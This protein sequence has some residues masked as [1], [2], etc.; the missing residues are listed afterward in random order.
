MQ[1]IPTA[2]YLRRVRKLLTESERIRAEA[3]IA[4]DP[5]AWPVVV[6]TGGIR[7]ARVRR[8]SR[9]KSGGARIIYLYRSASGRVYLMTIYAKSE[10]KDLSNEEKR[11]LREEASKLS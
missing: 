9:G 8:G 7:K 2:P 5:E 6:G 4:I 10:Q 11:I 1:I 3:E